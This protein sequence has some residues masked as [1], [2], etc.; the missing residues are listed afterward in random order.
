MDRLQKR[1]QKSLEILEMYTEAK[2]RGLLRHRDIQS[3]FL[4]A[5]FNRDPSKELQALHAATEITKLSM[6]PFEPPD[7]EADGP[8]R[9]AAG[10]NGIPIGMFPHECHVLIAGQTG[11]GKSTLLKLLF[12]QAL[13]VNRS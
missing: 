3:L 10:E 7:T 11:T 13:T 12:S 2:K 9:F 6:S 5:A 8:I 4:S 1:I